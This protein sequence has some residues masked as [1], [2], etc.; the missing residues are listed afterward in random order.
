MDNSGRHAQA[1]FR[2][3]APSR[4]IPVPNTAA[5]NKRPFPAGVP[6]QPETAATLTVLKP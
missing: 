4:R 1:Y 6:L 5:Q 3:P 2:G